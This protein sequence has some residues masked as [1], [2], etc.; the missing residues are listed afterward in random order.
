M[1]FLLVPMLAGGAGF[2]LG[3]W[4]GDLIGNLTK[5]AIVLAAMYLFYVFA[6]SEG[7]L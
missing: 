5:L 3:S 4:S 6:K 2:A 7:W 1:P